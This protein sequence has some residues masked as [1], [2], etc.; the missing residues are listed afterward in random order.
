MSPTVNVLAKIVSLTFL[1]VCKQKQDHN[2]VGVVELS[3][4][5]KGMAKS[6]PNF[7]TPGSHGLCLPFY[8]QI[9]SVPPGKAIHRQ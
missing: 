9:L 7:E 8:V 1:E 3:R 2:R 4:V 6:T 5:Y